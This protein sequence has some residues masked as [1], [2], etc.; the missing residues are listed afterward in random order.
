MLSKATK[1]IQEAQ[2][3]TS[4]L[5]LGDA[6]AASRVAR[7]C[8]RRP[9]ARLHVALS[10]GRRRV[11]RA[12]T[13]RPFAVRIDRPRRADPRTSQTRSVTLSFRPKDP[14]GHKGRSRQ[15]VDDL[16]GSTSAI[17][18]PAR[19]RFGVLDYGNGIALAIVMLVDSAAAGGFAPGGFARQGL[20]PVTLETG[21]NASTPFT[22]QAR[23]RTLLSQ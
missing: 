23:Q 11:A 7:S 10:A 15:P 6:D 19:A 13:N 1:R 12:A 3:G 9:R 16:G 5:A 18:Q 14:G 20:P 17:L 2:P 22:I 21:S 8:W 4:N